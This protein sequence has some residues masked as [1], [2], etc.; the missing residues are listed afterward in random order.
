[1]LACV[2]EVRSN[3]SGPPR[4]RSWSRSWSWR[5]GGGGP[6]IIEG[7]VRDAIT[8]QPIDRAA[9]DITGPGIQGEMTVQTGT[10]GR[11]RTNE[12]PHGEFGVRVRREGYK[13][14]NRAATMRDGIA[15]V[16]FELVPDR[17]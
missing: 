9:V 10:D 6:R 8:H 12:I 17:H 2:A 4:S 5:S 14:M 13:P 16:D 1:M 15:H 3:P 7:T 11:F